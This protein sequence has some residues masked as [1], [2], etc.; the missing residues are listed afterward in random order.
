MRMSSILPS[1]IV[2]ILL[3][4]LVSADTAAALEPAPPGAVFGCSRGLPPRVVQA[5]RAARSRA[6]A[7]PATASSRLAA[8]GAET[9]A[10]A[11]V[12]FARGYGGAHEDTGYLAK[13]TS[14]GGFILAGETASFGAGQKDAWIFKIDGSGAIVWQKTFGTVAEDIGEVAQ[15]TDGGF[16]LGLWTSS[17]GGSGG[18]PFT[19][20]KLTE[21]GA[22]SW[23]K[24]YGTA[25]DTFASVYPITGGYLLTASTFGFEGVMSTNTVVKLNSDGTIAWQKVYSSTAYH[26]GFIEQLADG[27]LLASGT[28]IDASTGSSDAFLAKLSATGQILWQK[29]YGGPGADYGS[30]AAPTADGGFMIVG[31]TQ[32]WG[33]NAGSD[34]NFDAWVL[35]LDG[36]GNLQWS[37]AYGGDKDEFA[38]VQAAGA[39]YVLT[40]VTDSFGAGNDDLFLATLSG[41][42]G[43]LTGKTYGGP[44]DDMGAIAPDSSGGGYLLQGTT[45]SFGAGNDDFL[46]AKLDASGNV[47]WQHTYGGANDEVGGATR[48][49]DGSL[50]VSGDTKSWGAGDWDAWAIKLNSSGALAASPAQGVFA[51][52]A[53]SLV[54]TPAIATAGFT[55][56][57]TPVAVTPGTDDFVE[58]TPT[59][60][61]GTAAITPGA[62]TAT[63]TDLCTAAQNLAATAAADT[64]SGAAPLTVAFTG[65]SAGGT[66]PYSYDWDFGDGSA[67][68]TQQNPSHVYDSGGTYLVTLTV[69]DA[70][71]HTATDTHLTVT[72]TGGGGTCTV[73]CTATVPA[74][75]TVGQAVAFAASATASGCSSA[76]AYVWMFGDAGLPSA[77]QNPSHVYATAGTYSWSLIVTAG[78][79]YCM[80]SGTITISAAQACALSCSLTVSVTGAAGEAL[81]FSVTATATN[82]TGTPTYAWTFG[83]GAT[84][85]ERSP[86]HTYASAGTYN[87]S[88]TV[89]Q[90]GKTCG[91]SGT[92]TIGA[93]PAG[94]TQWVPSIAHAPGAGTSKWRSNIAVVN[95]SGS[96]ANLTLVFVPYSSGSNVTKAY[97]LASGATVEWADVLVSLFAF[98]DSA[99]TKGS[100]KITSDTPVYAISRTYNQAASG[101]FGQYYPALIETASVTSGQ[102]AVLPMLKKNSGFRTNVG[103]QNL[104][105][106]ACTGTIK[107]YNAAG[108]QVGSARTLTAA[109]DKYIQ[110]DDVFTKA[111]AGTQ[112]VAYAIVEVTTAGGKAW[113]FAS[114]VDAVT[115]DPT[116]VPMQLAT[117]AGP[118]W[119]PSIAHAPGAGTSKWRSNIAIVN[120]SGS[121]ANLTLVF[122]PYS[123]GSSVT[124]SYTLADGAAV[125][126]GDVL[127]SLFA[128]A[129]SASTKGTVKL[130]A[131]VPVVA[132]SR[133]YNQAASGTFGQYYPALTDPASVTSGQTAVL[134]MLKKNSGFRTNVGVENLGA[135]SCTGTIKLFNAAGA[136]VGSTRTL[137]AAADKYI[138]DDDVF[139]KAGAGTQDVA[140]A[141]VEVTTA[142][143]KAWFYASVVD[144]VTNDPTTVP[145]QR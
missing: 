6:E 65:S 42:G 93:A 19:L 110:D 144:A 116:T 23:Q 122:T 100:V 40:G 112:D 101:T 36:S 88:V 84:S 28:R 92:I 137:T 128:F 98:A 70:A 45:D 30:Y 106:A 15:T 143:G 74:T 49:A 43:F 129:D 120:R 54:G 103:F 99:S 14:D 132:I 102:T 31:M 22:I 16:I 109:A 72:V 17:S 18:A 96:S 145:M 87:W 86:S 51:A 26:S 134:P 94:T 12:S 35:K 11:A 63:V 115:N 95:R 4:L 108:A 5:L 85:T 66:A 48:L 44:N 142:G 1:V 10:A 39:G 25:Q 79:G 91:G 123:A 13:A 121:S 139:A 58:S 9:T 89:S 55:F 46:L 131:N 133:T 71:A 34:Q 60:T 38:T 8:P 59:Y 52:A 136:Q 68:S 62:V 37:N 82:C 76:P 119:V 50:F 2:T 117:T 125:E 135:A 118:Y 130:T 69:T 97:T 113:F 47:T 7:D 138:Q 111:G 107:L 78:T 33:V 24:S 81:T 64:T 77:Q 114:V 140:Y 80:K 104:G 21:A 53:C 29:T 32:S 41:T 141:I 105:A 20:V 56:T 126:W 61:S 57:V 127:V 90:G 124:K 27:T 83:D 75:G 73:G 3:G 67:H